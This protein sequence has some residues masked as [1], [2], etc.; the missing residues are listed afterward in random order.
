MKSFKFRLVNK[1]S[2]QHAENVKTF[3]IRKIQNAIKFSHKLST[4]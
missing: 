4:V 2:L 1:R 3:T